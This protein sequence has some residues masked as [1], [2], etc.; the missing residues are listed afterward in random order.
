M[1]EV[2]IHE[3]FLGCFGLLRRD[4]AWLLVGNR[5]VLWQGGAPDLVF[6]LP[7]GRVEPGET[8]EE[9]L[10]REWQEEC[11][12]EIQVG[13]FCFV[14]EGIRRIQGVRHYAW[15]S[16]FFEVQSLGEPRASS[17]IESLL[18]CP[19]ARLP[20]VLQAPYHQG[21]LRYLE[22]RGRYQFDVWDG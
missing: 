12:L 17:E 4:E 19:D 9:C 16:F 22:N 10:L 11:A 6:D 5:R 14:Q 15:R 21:F 3:D 7:G 20:E 1:S 2:A 8:L 13:S 18:W